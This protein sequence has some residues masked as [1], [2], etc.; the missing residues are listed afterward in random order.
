[1]LINVLQR[2]LQCNTLCVWQVCDKL[3]SVLHLPDLA[4]AWLTCNHA[5]K[6]LSCQQ[7]GWLAWIIQQPH[8]WFNGSKLPKGSGVLYTTLRQ[9]SVEQVVIGGV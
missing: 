1:M 4:A 8:H 9:V 2:R 6:S 7:G 3:W 5:S